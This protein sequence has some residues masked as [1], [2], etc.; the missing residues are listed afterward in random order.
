MAS[1]SNLF[2]FYFSI[3]V[4]SY[5]LLVDDKSDF[6]LSLYLLVSVGLA[7]YAICNLA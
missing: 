7:M 5:E 3:L 4:K 1:Y 6:S 2:C